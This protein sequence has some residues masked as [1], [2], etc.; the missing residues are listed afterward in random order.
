M[1]FRTE[2]MVAVGLLL[3]GWVVS[4]PASAAILFGPERME[5]STGKPISVSRLFK[6]EGGQKALLTLTGSEA[7]QVS[8]GTVLLNGNKLVAP[9]AFNQQVARVERDVELLAEN[10]LE[11]NFA[12]PPGSFVVVT[13]TSETA[14]PQ[15]G[16]SISFDSL[17]D[18]PLDG[19]TVTT[20][21]LTVSGLLSGGDL[22][23]VGVVVNGIPAQ[24]SGN[25]FVAN[26]VPLM[27][28]TNILRAVATD[29]AGRSGVAS[30]QVAAVPTEEE[31][32]IDALASSGLAPMTLEL[33]TS[34][35]FYSGEAGRQV[36]CSGPAPVALTPLDDERYGTILSEPGLYLCTFEV[37]AVNGAVYRDRV[38][39]NVQVGAELDALLQA[40]WQGM[41]T[42][43]AADD[44]E[45]ALNHFTTES[46][47]K[48][49]NTFVRLQTQLPELAQT[50]RPPELVSMHGENVEYRVTRDQEF[51]GRVLPISYD[52]QFAKDIDGRWKIDEF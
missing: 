51:K 47:E 50:M 45:G 49:R 36:A 41:R 52:I 34:T 31:G 30:V 10:R 12:G 25:R 14:P 48:Y 39:I 15:N 1:R 43:L 38:G 40:R 18:G 33:L 16:P 4:V 35:S 21:N 26:H 8:S 2:K 9:S 23:D 46:R 28:G 19:A 17:P 7:K 20:A 27:A 3:V 44:I 24:V 22:R 29:A 13:V 37:R 42:A 32:E 11:L 6:A 5:I